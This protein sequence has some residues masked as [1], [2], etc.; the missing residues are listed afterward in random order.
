M[1]VQNTNDNSDY[2]CLYL[3]RKIYHVVVVNYPPRDITADNSSKTLV[4]MKEGIKDG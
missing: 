4:I 3:F 2:F 1:L